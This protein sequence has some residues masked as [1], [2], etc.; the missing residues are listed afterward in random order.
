MRAG[1]F[2]G[3]MSPRHGCWTAQRA[4]APPPS[5]ARLHPRRAPPPPAAPASER[6]TC[7]PPSERGALPRRGLQAVASGLV[8][9]AS[10]SQGAQSAIQSCATRYIDTLTPPPIPVDDDADDIPLEDTCTQRAAAVLAG[11]L[12]K[13]PAGRRRCR[14]AS[15]LAA[16]V[17]MVA[18]PARAV[19]H[20]LASLAGRL[21]RGHGTNVA[22]DAAALADAAAAAPAALP[23]RRAA[24]ACRPSLSLGAAAAAARPARLACSLPAPASA[25]VGGLANVSNR[26]GRASR[27]AIAGA[28][29]A[30]AMAA[31]A[32]ASAASGAAALPD[33]AAA[34]DGGSLPAWDADAAAAAAAMA[35]LM[36]L[37]GVGIAAQCSALSVFREERGARLMEALE[38]IRACPLGR[39]GPRGAEDAVRSITATQGEWRHQP[40]GRRRGT[41]LPGGVAPS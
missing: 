38:G 39:V 20:V 11:A 14:V 40:V 35:D 9:L 21:A 12:A 27:R 28:A 10:L 7:S 33:P 1:Q 18:A 37:C 6:S 31:P 16:P 4:P 23:A 24:A 25:V 17:C 30:S 22:C 19:L 41:C 8:D 34:S 26:C 36:S 29:A 3:G 15:T 32:S 5:S 2:S 13:A